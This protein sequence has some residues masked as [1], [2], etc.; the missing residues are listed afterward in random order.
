ME[1]WH[2]IKKIALYEPTTD[3]PNTY[4]LTVSPRLGLPTIGSI[5]KSNGYAVDLFIEGI[6]APS[7]RELLGYDLI[8]ISVLTNTSVKG[9]NYAGKLKKSGKRVVIGGPHVTFLPEDGLRYCDFVVRGEG[10]QTLPEL[11]DALNTSGPLDHIKGLSY[12]KNGT[13]RHNHDRALKTDYLEISPDY[14]LI[15][16]MQKFSQGLISKYRFIPMMYTSRGCP[17]NCRY[18]TVFRFAGQK[19][20]YRSLDRC[21]EDI[22]TITGMSRKDIGIADDNFTMN[23][24]RTKEFLKKLILLKI[25]KRYTFMTQVKVDAFRDEELMALL[26]EA[27]FEILHVG[28]ESINETT[29]HDWQKKQSLDE[30]YF[31]VAQA[32]KYGQKINAMFVVGS[33]Y[34]TPGTIKATV[35]FAIKTDMAVMQMWILTP[36]PGSDVFR[37]TSEENRIFNNHWSHYDCQHSVFFPL[38]MKPSTLQKAVRMANKRFYKYSRM[39]LNAPGN[40]ITYGINAHLMNKWMRRYENKLHKI[41]DS[42]YTNDNRLIPEALPG[43]NRDHTTKCLK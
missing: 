34:D 13:V 5:L 43:L 19:P 1:T 18:C 7:I 17:F 24:R 26:K 9:F 23:I 37:Q 20:R 16:G 10:E 29:L 27:N 14:G 3:I 6:Q 15:R 32:K 30:I 8:G 38:R 11:I 21:I 41:E 28:Y 2:M 39:F 25:P 40:R 12:W 33:D 36:L 35:D 42:F 4:S 31:T 22:R